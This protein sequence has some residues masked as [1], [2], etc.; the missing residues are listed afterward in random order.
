M[1]K[2][3][4]ALTA[5]VVFTVSSANAQLVTGVGDIGY[6]VGSG[7]NRSVLVLDFQDG[8]GKPAFAWGYAYDGAP[9]GAEMLLDIAAADPNLELTYTG[10]AEAGFYMSKISY[11]DGATIHLEQEGDFIVDSRYWGY[12][13][14]GGTAGGNFSPQSFDLVDPGPS[15]T[16]PSVW[17]ES[18]SGASSISY[19]TPGRFVANLSWD[20]W[21]F[22]EWGTVPATTIY[23]AAAVPE[24]SS[25]ALLAL[26]A[27]LFIF[28]RI[29][30][31]RQ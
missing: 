15:S 30:H 23:A 26:S 19:G 9:S 17:L 18:P 5:L 21:T 25:W 13:V 27:C 24:P 20:A 16:L 28:F 12:S 22:G 2:L 6:W 7:A 4:A 10:T 3:I 8:S 31:A 14:A 29:R 11:F 1:K